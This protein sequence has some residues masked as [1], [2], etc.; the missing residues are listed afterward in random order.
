MKL[1]AS[2][3]HSS[4]SQSPLKPYRLLHVKGIFTLH[5]LVS[6]GI[7][8]LCIIHCC[9]FGRLARCGNFARSDLMALTAD[10]L[11][12]GDCNCLP[13]AGYGNSLWDNP[14]SSAGTRNQRLRAFGVLSFRWATVKMT[15]DHWLMPATATCAP[16]WIIWN[17]KD[18]L[19]C[20]ERTTGH[21]KSV[22]ADNWVNCTQGYSKQVYR[23]EYRSWGIWLSPQ[24][25]FVSCLSDMV[26]K[27]PMTYVYPPYTRLTPFKIN[28]L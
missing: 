3:L 17:S 23:F 19:S 4:Q 22:A 13:E 6:E 25:C 20:C 2:N 27:V 10:E 28:M 5:L 14:Y 1:K 8:H 7:L 9:G 26:S 16:K 21:P 24:L 11:W 15:W 12:L 18:Q